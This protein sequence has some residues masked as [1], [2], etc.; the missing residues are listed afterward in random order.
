MSAHNSRKSAAPGVVATALMIAGRDLRIELRARV[1]TNQVI[2]FAAVT[3]VLFAFAVDDTGL[4][5]RLAPGLIWLTVMF[6]LLLCAQRAFAIESADGALEALRVA[7]VDP[8]GIFLGKA[9]ALMAQLLALSAV[10]V[11]AA[12]VLYDLSP[13][14]AGAVVLVTSVICA[15][16]ALAA[17]GTIY[18]GLAAG[19]SGRE[20][21]LPLLVLPVV[22]PVLI[23]ATRAVEA[24]LGTGEATVADG[25]PWV[26]LLAVV[27]VASVVIGSLTFGSAIQE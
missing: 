16:C 21:L 9:M 22:S 15:T 13:P 20:T 2:P 11:V 3:M 8:I 1:V 19:V 10:M 18:A 14:A 24:A 5:G 4:L 17:T 27:A 7:G 25:W 6:S 12:L 26:G 23:G